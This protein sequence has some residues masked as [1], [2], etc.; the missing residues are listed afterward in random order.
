MAAA[1][2]FLSHRPRSESEMWARL[3]R[4]FSQTVIEEAVG[5]LKGWRLLD[6]GEFARFWLQNRE[7]LRPRGRSAIKWELLRKGVA[8]EV[9]EDVLAGADEE[10][11]A[12]RA[13]HQ[14]LGRLSDMGYQAFR[15]KLTAYL[16]RRGFAARATRETV[17]RLW[18]ELSDPADGRVEGPGDDDQPEDAK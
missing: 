12:Y 10:G 9:V 8:R 15:T 6:D 2:R 17:E 4:R 14:V 13:A 7:R 18:G 11:N 1:R 16:R 3:S 5:L